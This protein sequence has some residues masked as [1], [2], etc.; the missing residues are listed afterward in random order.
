VIVITNKEYLKTHRIFLKRKNRSEE[1]VWTLF[2]DQANSIDPGI[3]FAEEEI[4][5]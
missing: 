4:E 1:G 5:L 2:E 3:T